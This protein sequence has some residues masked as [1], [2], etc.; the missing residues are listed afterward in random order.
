M[1]LFT[2]PEFQTVSEISGFE[3]AK[4]FQEPFSIKKLHLQEIESTLSTTTN[5]EGLLIAFVLCE[6]PISREETFWLE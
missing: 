1:T 4:S 2:F 3:V 6:K 5:M